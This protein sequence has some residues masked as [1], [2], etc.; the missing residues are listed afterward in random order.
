M[1]WITIPSLSQD[2][3]PQNECSDAFKRIDT[4]NDGFL[5]HTEIP[6]AKDMPAALA[7]AVLVG[8]QEFM[9]ACVKAAEAKQAEKAAPSSPPGES[10][11][12]QTPPSK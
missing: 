6:K 10:P 2:A 11:Q 8:R 1:V 12:G 3:T 4:N 7:K 9:A 5:T